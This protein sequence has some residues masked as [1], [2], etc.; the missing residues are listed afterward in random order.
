MINLILSVIARENTKDIP[1]IRSKLKKLILPPRASQ[2][3]SYICFSASK[4]AALSS[5]LSLPFVIERCRWITNIQ[6]E[7]N[8]YR[9]KRAGS[10][11]YLKLYEKLPR[12]AFELPLT[13]SPLSVS[14]FPE[15]NGI[16][17]VMLKC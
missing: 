5:F 15:K 4:A 8:G 7:L 6:P 2:R 13:P 14:L 3:G 10:V 17:L 1:L 11:L 12:A 16:T 9:A